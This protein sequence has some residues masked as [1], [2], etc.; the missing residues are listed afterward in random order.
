MTAAELIAK[1][2]TLPPDMRVIT[3]YGDDGYNDARF[4]EV[5][6]TCLNYRALGSYSGPHE[7][8]FWLDDEEKQ[9][10]VIEQCALIT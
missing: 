1:L 3:R 5:T 8:N 7:T 6:E 4:V 10:F 9:K 2:Q